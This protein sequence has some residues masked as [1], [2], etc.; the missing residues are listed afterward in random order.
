MVKRLDIYF[1]HCSTLFESI[2]V[3][4]TE[5]LLNN[6]DSPANY[7]SPDENEN[8]NKTSGDEKYQSL[9]SAQASVSSDEPDDQLTDAN[10]TKREMNFT[11]AANEIQ[12]DLNNLAAMIQGVSLISTDDQENEKSARDDDDDKT[13]PS[14]IPV[15]RRPMFDEDDDTSR[16]ATQNYDLHDFEQEVRSFSPYLQQIQLAVWS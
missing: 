9:S 2:Q 12:N 1:D 15:P 11:E 5:L 4:V 7:L 8:L 6:L 10:P 14:R 3:D 13:E 16:Q